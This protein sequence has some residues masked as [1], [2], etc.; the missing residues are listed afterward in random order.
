MPSPSLILLDLTMPIMNGYEFLRRL[1]KNGLLP[2]TPVVVTSAV[3]EV[4]DGARV[5]LRKPYGV[6]RL[7]EVIRRFCPASQADLTC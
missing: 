6:S 1:R 7:M 5:L 4:P 3:N 2:R